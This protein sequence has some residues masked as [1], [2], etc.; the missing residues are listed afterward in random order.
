MSDGRADCL[1]A[2][3]VSRETAEALDRYAALLVRWQASIN[4]VGPST[5]PDLWR[6]HILDSGQ[7]LRLILEKTGRAP[8]LALLDMGAGA[9]FPGLVLAIMGLGRAQLVES[10]RKKCAFLR[11]A[12]QATGC[13]AEVHASR[14]EALADMRVDIVTARALAPVADLLALG[15]RFL[16]PDGEMWLLKGRDADGELTRARQCWT[17]DVARYPSLTH[18]DGRIVR[19]SAIEKQNGNRT[20]H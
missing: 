19:L 2:L 8:P 18:E 10:D 12:I 7:L 3:D 1:K 5:L 14:I 15:H 9:G 20:G 6:R 11:Q 16:A 4:L 17:F 13:K